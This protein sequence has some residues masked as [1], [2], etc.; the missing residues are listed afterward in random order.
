MCETIM[1]GFSQNSFGNSKYLSEALKGQTCH[2]IE[3]I[4]LDLAILE[5]DSLVN[6]T[7]Q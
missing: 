7:L 5:R 2:L 4:G 3:K 1:I 6:K